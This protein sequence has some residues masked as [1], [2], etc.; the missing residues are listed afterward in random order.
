MV[1]GLRLY[2]AADVLLSQDSA[3]SIRSSGA[4][5]G[6][7]RA[8][9]AAEPGGIEQPTGELCLM[10]VKAP[11]VWKQRP[12]AR[13]CVSFATAHLT[14]AA[15]MSGLPA[16]STSATGG[17]GNCDWWNRLV[18]AAPKMGFSAFPSH[19]QSLSWPAVAWVAGRCLCTLTGSTGKG[20]RLM[21]RVE[22]MIAGVEPG[23]MFAVS[24]YCGAAGLSCRRWCEGIEKLQA[25]LGFH[26]A[27]RIP[28]CLLGP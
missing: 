15:P 26:W 12:R 9:A 11:P 28:G 25:W 1:L 4:C 19:S 10:D 21:D 7:V 14:Q 20:W 5:Q 6:S 8:V 27:Y 16:T 13:P 24:A 17:V 18:P 22:T 23:A 2:A 3:P